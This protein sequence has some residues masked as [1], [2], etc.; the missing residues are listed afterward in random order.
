AGARL[1]MGAAV[2]T[3]IVLLQ[4]SWPEIVVRGQN[5][6]SSASPQDSFLIRRFAPHDGGTDHVR[7][8]FGGTWLL[9]AG[10]DKSL[11][12]WGAR[13]GNLVRTL[14]LDD[15][16]ATALAVTGQ[17]AATGH[18]NGAI[19][20]WDLETGERLAR[21]QRNEARIWSVTFLDRG[22]TLAAAAHDWAVTL[23]T[24]KTPDAPTHVFA[25]HD[26]AAHAVAYDPTRARLVS[27]S[28]D[29]TVKL[30]DRRRLSLIRTYRGHKDFVTAV[31]VSADGKRI[32]SGDLDGQI[33][34][35]SSRGSR[36][37]ARLRAHDGEVSGISFLDGGKRIASTSTDG[38]L[39]I[40]DVR[41]GR[42][43]QTFGSDGQRVLSMSADPKATRIA[44]ASDD[45]QVRIWDVRK[46]K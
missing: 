25:G 33:R 34:V 39:T 3:G 17:R 41:R 9:T 46:L 22:E 44:T 24:A 29:K 35:W 2:A 32:A 19:A 15:G 21:F 18:E 8:A 1:A 14:E 40:W 23:W 12:I 38:R 5:V 27:A 42:S 11:K 6:A 28:A 13:W 10:A 4:Q 45:G 20:I 30:W 31:A 16:R 7:F 43:Q 26:S 36:R 37:I